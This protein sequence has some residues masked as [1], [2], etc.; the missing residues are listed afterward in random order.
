MKKIVVFFLL[1]FLCAN[2]KVSA[3]FNVIDSFPALTSV[4]PYYSGQPT[5]VALAYYWFDQAMRTYTT[6]KV[7]SFFNA[8]QY[9]DTAKYIADAM[10]RVN[11]DNPISFFQWH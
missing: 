11:G 3:Q 8:M 7:D 2:A 9:S 4:P 1:L 10:Y 5:A 6:Y